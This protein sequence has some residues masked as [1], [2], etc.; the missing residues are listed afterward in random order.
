MSAQKTRATAF[1]KELAR[2]D[3]IVIPTKNAKPIGTNGIS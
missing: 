2:D 1:L 3:Q